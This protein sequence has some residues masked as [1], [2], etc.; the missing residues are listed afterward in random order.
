MARHFDDRIRAREAGRKGALSFHAKRR[1]LREPVQPFAGSILEMMD[2]ASLT[3][4]SWE[5]W[6]SFWRAIYALPMEEADLER[7]TRHTAR[8]SAPSEPVREAWLIVGRRGGKSRMA[9]LA[10]LYQSIRRN[11]SELL[12]PGERGMILVIA[13][14][15]Q[16]ARSTLGY[17]KG[18]VKLDPFAPFVSRVLKD[19]VELRTGAEIRVGTASFR[20]TRGYTLVGVVC[21]EIAFWLSDETGANPDSEILAALRP[22]MA[23]VPTSLLLGLSSPYAA[24]GELYKA[25]TRYT[26]A[27]DPAGIAWNADTLSMNPGVDPRVI[28]DAFDDD[29]LAAASEYGRDGTVVFRRDVESF[30]DVEAVRA[31]TMTG[32]RELAPMPG[33]RYTAFVDPSGGSQDSFTLAIAH[34]EKGSAVLDLVREVRPPFSPEGVVSEF[35]ATLKAYRV[36]VVTGDKYAGEWPR[37]RFRVHGLRYQPSERVKSDLY[38]ELLPLVNAGR[39]QL[40]DSSRLA[41]QL[42]G[43]ERRV[44]RGGKDSIDH[45]PG[46]RDDLANAVAGALVLANNSQTRTLSGVGAIWVEV[47]EGPPGWPRS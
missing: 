23:T 41:T 18:L 2:A 12:A 8:T 5:P 15:R 31:V 39:V 17:L 35:V 21:E 3:G 46:G 38:R 19:S 30:L 40:L 34:S 1:A 33:L 11:Y 42:M 28:A 44:A 43:L 22:G 24:K 10:A 45:A 36:A 9:A 20:T 29:P 4:A 16:Q 32:R 47:S 26:G 13:A 27:D 14:D 25:Y 6:R 7:F 37:E